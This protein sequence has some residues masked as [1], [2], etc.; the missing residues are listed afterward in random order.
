MMQFAASQNSQSLG[1]FVNLAIAAKRAGHDEE[2]KNL[3]GQIKE[4]LK[5][6]AEVM[7]E[8]APVLAE[9]DA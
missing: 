4:A 9:I 8:L 2:A 5:D 3:A 6:N 7:N 1:I